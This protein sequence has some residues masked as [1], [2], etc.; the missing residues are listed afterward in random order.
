MK[1]S[2]LARQWFRKHRREIFSLAATLLFFVAAEFAVRAFNLVGRPS[3]DAP[4]VSQ[5]LET[6]IMDDPDLFWRFRPNQEME[7]DGRYYHINSISLRDHEIA[8]PKPAGVY[9]IL[10]LGESTSFGAGVADDE[11]YAKVVERLLR[12][13]FPDRT[14][15]VVNAGVGAYSSFQCVQ[16]LEKYGLAL[17][18]DMV[19]L[20][21]GAND[22]LA[23][24]VRNYANLKD[25]FGYTDKELY[26][27]RHRWAGLLRLL[28]RSDLYKLFKQLQTGRLLENYGQNVA[29]KEDQLKKQRVWRPRVPLDDRRENLQRY[30]DLAAQHRVV[31]VFLLPAYWT[32]PAHPEDVMREVAREKKVMLIDLPAAL[33]ASGQF[34]KCW[35]SMDEVG[36][37]PNATGHR[38]MAETIVAALIPYFA[39]NSLT[40]EETIPEP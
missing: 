31:P 37:H 35:F 19:M 13:R 8:V 25:G 14:W 23:S 11:T 29:G 15:E 7:G 4:G 24:Y 18:P 6:S 38:L 10:S 20:F 28:N 32:S 5:N 2:K 3:R 36:G 1:R 27:V 21:S 9:R 39:N 16:Y 40:T 12:E 33:H 17:Q 30:A 34:E 26:A 22:G